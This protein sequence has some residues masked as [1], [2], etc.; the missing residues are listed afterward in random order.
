[1][2]DWENVIYMATKGHRV[3]YTLM[4][5]GLLQHFISWRRVFI[6]LRYGRV[7]VFYDTGKREGEKVRR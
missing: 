3:S 6:V 5:S 4:E 7:R 1:M 2:L